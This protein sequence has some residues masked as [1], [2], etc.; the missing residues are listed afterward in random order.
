[1]SFAASKRSTSDSP[2]A[3]SPP[4]PPPSNS[5][6]K[7]AGV[8][9]ESLAAEA[10]LRP[11]DR[12]LAINDRPI[13]D[14]LDYRF[15]STEE[16]VALTVIHDGET[17]VVEFEKP[18]DE[19]LG[20]EFTDDAFDGTRL[21]NNK[22][23]FCFL[24]GLPKGLRRTLYVK[25]DDYRL[26]FLHGNFITLTNLS[27][28]DWDRLAEQRLSPL[29]ISV[30]ATDPGLRRVMLGNPRAP[31]I[32]AQLRRLHDMGIEAHTQVVLCPGVNDGPALDVTV[33][34]L[35]RHP[36]V[37]SIGVVP[38]GASLDGEARIAQD[39][40]RAC[41]PEAAR[42]LLRQLR[43]WQRAAAA[44]RGTPTVYASD[45]FYLTAG[46]RIPA[47]RFYAGAPQWENGV[48]MVRSLLDDWTRARRRLRA[49]RY[50]PP[51]LQH[52]TMACGLVIGPML[53]RLAAEASDL[54]GIRI[55][56][57][58][59]RN[60][61]FGERVNVAGLLPGRDFQTQLAAVPGG[62]GERVFLPRASLD[63]FGTR[64]LDELTPDA[65]ERSLERPLTFAYTLSEVIEWSTAR[66]G[67]TPAVRPPDRS[68][69][70]AWTS[71][72]A[73]AGV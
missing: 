32:R 38:V 2:R 44:A 45:E 14:Q 21:C 17:A 8:T 65:L 28:A 47:A 40:M 73:S 62:L 37:R 1:M 50:P 35:L 63:Y 43:P 34:E 54:L 16:F 66:D 30:H 11:G 51:R 23:F 18:P 24:K 48:G 5:T 3:F 6:G 61:L 42:H 59:I 64:F 13:T 27:D 56:V 10:G 25:D 9:P 29:H 26:S 39:G 22:C 58:P 67:E 57:V 15:R 53:T 71:I 12:V 69:G 31:D 49:G 7:I 33:E 19:P 72:G 41:T 4:V 52:V 70:R 36:N 55:D 68:N 20:V 46:A 60:T